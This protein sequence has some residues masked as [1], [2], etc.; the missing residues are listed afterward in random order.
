M[1]GCVDLGGW[2]HTEMF[3]PPAN[4]H[5]SSTNRARRRVAYVD[6]DQRRYTAK[7]RNNSV[8]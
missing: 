5:P 8:S 3:Y 2:L 7:P 1:E 6:Q 4:G